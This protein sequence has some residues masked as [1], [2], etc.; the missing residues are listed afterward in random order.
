MRK[1]HKRDHALL[2]VADLYEEFWLLDTFIRI[3]L[4]RINY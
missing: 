2:G 4:T 1:V 3:E